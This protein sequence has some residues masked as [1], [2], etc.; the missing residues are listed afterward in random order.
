MVNRNMGRWTRLIHMTVKAM[1]HP[2]IAGNNILHRSPDRCLGIDI[3][4]GIVTGSTDTKVR[5]ENIGPVLHRMTVGAG[6]GVNLPKISDRINCH[7]MIDSPAGGAVVMAGEI[8]GVTV[9]ALPSPIKSRPLKGS[10]SDSVTGGATASSMN[11]TCSNKRRNCG[12]MTPCTVNSCRT[13][14]RILLNRGA[15]IMVVTIKIR[16]MTGSTRSATTTVDRSVTV[17]VGANNA[18]AVDTG[19]AHETVVAVH[20]THAVT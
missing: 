2:G 14:G 7:R 3:P 15:V 5:R 13:G 19:V 1:N 10:A 12:V 6:L 4:S 11:L 18:S 17:A 20:Y 8:Q 16:N 9:D